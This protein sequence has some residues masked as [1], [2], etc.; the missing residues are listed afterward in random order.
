MMMGGDGGR[1]YGRSS[2]AGEVVPPPI[3]KRNAKS[4]DPAAAYPP[5]FSFSAEQSP[6]TQSLSG[7]ES[8]RRCHVQSH[9]LMRTTQRTTQ[10][11]TKGHS[12]R[13]CWPQ[14][15]PSP[16]LV[17]FQLSSGCRVP[18][19]IPK[20]CRTISS[21]QTNAD[22]ST[23]KAFYWQRLMKSSKHSAQTHDSEASDAKSAWLRYRQVHL[24][25]R[26]LGLQDKN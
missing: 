12:G 14:T 20:S 22:M 25:L 9:T 13:T 5:A 8:P 3:I 10:P 21:L 6:L 7:N 16:R 15:L 2:A 11:E 24:Q 4:T 26:S 23:K 17:T 1:R 18:P 19:A